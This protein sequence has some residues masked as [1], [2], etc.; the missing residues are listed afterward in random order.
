M[1]ALIQVI[2]LA[3]DYQLGDTVVHALAGVSLSIDAGEFVAVMGPSGSGKSTFMNLIGCLDRP[4]HG[5]YTLA[6]ED[7][8]AMNPDQLAAIRNRR[9]GFVFQQFN[10]LPRTPALENV[11]LPLIYAGVE[12]KERLRRAALKLDQVG[13]AHRLRSHPAQLSGGQQQRV[14]IARAL[15][16]DPALILA[17]EPTGA[18]D[19]VT[20]LEIV[21]LLRQLNRGGMTI[22]V[23]THERDIAEFASRVISFLDGRVVNDVRQTPRNCMNTLASLK[24]HPHPNPPLEGEGEKCARETV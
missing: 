14:A 6:G 19:S 5:G 3:K 4:T 8:A 23:V 21:A 2:D 12:P 24:T 7:V 17:D 9:V 22:V 15:V 20:S 13:L 16:N 18:L 10:L 11:E 1:P